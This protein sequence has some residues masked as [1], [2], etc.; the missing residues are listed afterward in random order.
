MQA[1]R[2]FLQHALIRAVFIFVVLVVFGCAG[3]WLWSAQLDTQDAVSQE[4]TEVSEVSR[5]SQNPEWSFKEI[6][7]YFLN[8][9]AQKGGAYAYDVLRKAELPPNTDMHLLGHVIGNE[10]Y[11]QQG[12]EGMRVC[13]QDFRNACSHAIVVGLFGDEGEVALSRIVTACRE[14]PGGS[15]AYNMCFHGLGHGVFAAYGY[16]IAKTVE[17]CKK[18]G[19]RTGADTP[20]ATECIGGMVMELMGG[21]DHDRERWAVKRQEYVRAE[22]PLLPCSGP[23]IPKEATY[24]CYVYLTPHLFQAAGA[25]LGSPKPEEFKKAFT[26]CDVLPADDLRNRDACFGGFGKEFVVL[27][28]DR[29][30][31]QSALASITDAQ[32]QTVSEWCDLAPHAQ[33]SA[34]CVVHAMNSLYWG[35][36]NPVDLPLRFCKTLADVYLS[37][38][39]F[40]ALF[41]AVQRYAQDAPSAARVCAEA[42]VVLQDRCKKILY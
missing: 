23:L 11:A 34:A 22:Q 36:E 17:L 42:P 6:S 26:Y 12:V 8:V 13:T 7:D 31:R 21:G 1:Y 39:C 32:L 19:S 29:D 14:A 10:L 4:M 38:S 15:G 25:S 16:D 24:I 5:L 41:S 3:V 30:I 35:A 37:G 27:A 20:E 33:A 40:T 2:R 28:R 9:A 18:T